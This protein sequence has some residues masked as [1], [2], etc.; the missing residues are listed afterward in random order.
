MDNDLTLDVRRILDE[1]TV[2]WEGVEELDY[3]VLFCAVSQTVDQTVPYLQDWDVAL[4]EGNR[5][6]W[7][8]LCAAHQA[9]MSEMFDRACAGALEL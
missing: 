6:T 3:S 1:T 7:S 9:E 5:N 2:K 8:A 4:S